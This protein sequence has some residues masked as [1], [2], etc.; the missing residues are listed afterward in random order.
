M[1][2]VRIVGGKTP[3]TGWSP[4][5][6]ARRSIDTT[7]WNFVSPPVYFCSLRGLKDLWLTKGVSAPFDQGGSWGTVAKNGFKIYIGYDDLNANAA[8]ATCA[9][10][11]SNQWSVEWIGIEGLRAEA[12]VIDT[13]AIEWAGAAVESREPEVKPEPKGKKSE[14]PA[15]P[16]TVPLADGQSIIESPSEPFRKK[17]LEVKGEKANDGTLVDLW[18][19]KEKPHQRW[20]LTKVDEEGGSVYY[21]IEHPNSSLVMEALGRPQANGNSVVMRNYDQNKKN[22]QWKF[23]PVSGQTGVYQIATREGGLVIDIEH[24]TGGAGEIKQYRSY[25]H[26]DARQHWKLTP[27]REHAQ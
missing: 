6:G 4:S 25:P 16:A 9:E 22:H 3:H 7:Q 14:P 5:Y 2:T 13:S 27:F 15:K 12:W 8:D 26:R 20:Q 17:V 19:N 18:E 21:K 10:S 24:G 11:D 23:V 1:G